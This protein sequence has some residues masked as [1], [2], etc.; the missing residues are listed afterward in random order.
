MSAHHSAH[1]ENDPTPVPTSNVRPAMSA[2][3]AFALAWAEIDLEASREAA[4]LYGGDELIELEAIAAG[5]H[6]KQRK[7][8]A[9]ELDDTKRQA[10][11]ALVQIRNK[12]GA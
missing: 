6:P 10:A 1:P 9:P 2:K 7:L 5:T 12:L 3:E 4:T 8:D 11:G